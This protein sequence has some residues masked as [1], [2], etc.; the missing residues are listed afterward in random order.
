MMEIESTAWFPLEEYAPVRAGWYEVQLSSGETAFSKFADGDWTEKPALVFTHWRGL[1]ADPSQ[2]GET[3]NID[4]EATAA[5]GVRAAWNA[6][7]P[8]LADEPKQG[9]AQHKS[10]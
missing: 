4:A 3:E 2:S 9:D 5:E 7:F 1:S 10:A 6:F 8:A